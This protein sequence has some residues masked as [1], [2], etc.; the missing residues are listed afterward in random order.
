MDNQEKRILIEFLG[1]CYHTYAGIDYPY[2][3]RAKC[4]KCGKYT[5]LYDDDF[6][7][8]FTDWRITGRLVEKVEGLY[9]RKGAFTGRWRAGTLQDKRYVDE[10]G[11][12]PQEAVCKA[13][14]TY[15]K[16]KT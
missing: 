15:L 6:E 10:S 11:D 8:D 9:I 12:T 7:P 5:S 16:E 2:G 13:V 3:L 14:L 4:E 1:E